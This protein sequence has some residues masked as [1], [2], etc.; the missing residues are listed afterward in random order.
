MNSNDTESTTVQHKISEIYFSA[1]IANHL[2]AFSGHILIAGTIG[3]LYVLVAMF[4]RTGGHTPPPSPDQSIFVW[5]IQNYGYAIL[6]VLGS[7]ITGLMGIKLLG[8]SNIHTVIPP[9]D[10]EVLAPLILEG[11]KAAID[12]Y[13][14]LSS[15]NGF[16]GTFQKIGFTGLPLAT[17]ILTL[18]FSGLSF[19]EKEFLDFAKLTLGAFIG[20]FVQKGSGTKFTKKT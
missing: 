5:T 9:Q 12:Q 18:I 19:Y 16:T 10:Y 7:A 20:S 8:A 14:R 17:A 13:V 1:P 3:L 4:M 11:K 6:I 15:L 2:M